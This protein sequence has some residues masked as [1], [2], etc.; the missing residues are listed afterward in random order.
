MSEPQLAIRSAL[1]AVAVP[2]HHGARGSAGATLTELANPMLVSI[3]VRGEQTAALSAAIE[4]D[5]GVA[6]PRRPGR[7]AQD[8]VAFIW[9]GCDQWLAVG[10]QADDLARRLA[11]C[12]GALGSVTD[13]SG[14]RTIIHV[15]G[16]RARAGLMKVVPTDLDETAFTTGS[17]A[18]TVAAHI[19]VQLWQVDASPAYEIACPRSFGASLWRT[20]S[21][22]FSEYGYEV[23]A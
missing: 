20:L 11:S 18:L 1:T 9:S 23:R 3:A 16:A 6:L 13:L 8:E 19:P 12:A 4:R 5:F 17:A 14:S 15:G 21:A 2:G 22:A 7:A 10:A